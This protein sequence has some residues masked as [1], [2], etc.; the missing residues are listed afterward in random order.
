MIT[1]RLGGNN[2]FQESLFEMKKHKIN[3]TKNK[4]YNQRKSNANSI[5]SNDLDISLEIIKYDID[6]LDD[7][8]F[9]PKKVKKISTNY[10][11]QEILLKI[12]RKKNTL[13]K[14]MN[15]RFF[16]ESLKDNFG[17][18]INKL[19]STINNINKNIQYSNKLDY[20][21]F[22]ILIDSLCLLDYKG[23]T[24]NIQYISERDYL[25]LNKKQY[26]EILNCIKQYKDE[27]LTN[28]GFDKL[29]LD[30]LNNLNNDINMNKNNILQKDNKTI[31][32][33]GIGEMKRCMT[34]N[35]IN[36]NNKNLINCNSEKIYKTLLRKNLLDKFYDINKFELFRLMTNNPKLS[37]KE[38][39]NYLNKSCINV[40]KAVEKYY[41]HLYKTDNLILTFFYPEITETEKKYITHNFNFTSPISLL[42]DVA[43]VDYT[44]ALNV[45]LFTNKKTEIDEKEKK[46]KCIGGLNLENNSV[47]TVIKKIR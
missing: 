45:S 9:S 38:I 36:Q 10:Y 24:N 31:E 32:V 7:I 8:E 14:I 5:K 37:N 28:I 39:S 4:E 20:K 30:S 13:N 15:S 6:S 18:E 42:F 27:M 46:I 25:K 2:V 19:S 17:N 35:N 11:N 23:I 44:H 1:I 3:I 12:F 47:I 33:D 40:T 22:K 34:V 16:D 29:S 43:I 21:N 26:N 41:Q